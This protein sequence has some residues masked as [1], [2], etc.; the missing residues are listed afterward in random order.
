MK[1]HAEYTEGLAALENFEEGMKDLFKVP[2]R[3]RF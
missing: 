1:K 2:K 3:N